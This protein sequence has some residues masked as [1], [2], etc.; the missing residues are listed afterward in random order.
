MTNGMWRNTFGAA[1]LAVTLT[2]LGCAGGPNR[3][4]TGQFID[5]AAIT[6]KAKAALL[7]DPMVNGFQVNVDTYKDVVQL[8]GFVDSPAQKVR[9]E[10]I[11]WGIDGV[12][13]VKNHLTVREV[14]EPAPDKPA[15]VEQERTPSSVEQP[16]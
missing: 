11:V 8:S 2:W 5:S 9:A 4:S 16:D 7:D 14:V 12:R 3:Q 13:A 1:C 15:P 10:E 6:A